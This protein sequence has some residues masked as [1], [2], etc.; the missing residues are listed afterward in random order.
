MTGWDV[1]WQFLAG[2]AYS[3]VLGIISCG[4][5]AFGVWKVFKK[6]IM[7]WFAELVEDVVK[8]HIKDLNE[9]MD[10]H[11]DEL[12]DI[13]DKQQDHELQIAVMQRDY[14]SLNDAL[15]NTV[16]PDIVRIKAGVDELHRLMIGFG[17]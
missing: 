3:I 2:G 11:R 8:T 6:S 12:E 1:V 14:S 7:R 5:V 16:M 4:F 15:K 17:K 9:R 10:R 13:K